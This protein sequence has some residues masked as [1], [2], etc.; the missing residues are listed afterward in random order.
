MSPLQRIRIVSLAQNV[1]GPVAA[2]RLLELG[3][4][5]VKVEP[6][7]GDPLSRH[8][9][10]WYASLSAGQQVRRIDLKDADGR[11][12]LES[13]LAGCDLLLTSS[14]PSALARL[15]LDWPRLH[16][17]HPHLSH[18]AI[19]G[20]A[21]PNGDAPGHDLTYLAACGLIEP[22][23]MPPTLMADLAG[24]ERAVSAALALLFARERGDGPGYAEV[25]LAAVAESL[26][27]PLRH[28]LTA[29]G[30]RLGG[31]WPGYNL[32]A[33]QGGWLAAAALEPH[34]WARLQGE[35][36]LQDAS[37][38]ELAAVFGARTAEEWARWAAERDLPL[39]VVETAARL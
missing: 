19:V 1:P 22:P 13:L 25:A 23:R 15:E 31:G 26:A 28:G 20:H 34:F 7:T 9:P 38:D 17:R 16:G 29:P 39:A 36:G 32:Y 35:L 30:G 6:P 33:A 8:A 10:E 3:A 12:E 24:A 5:L 37:Y 11:A 21:A 18:V 2:A 14:R 27:A 4:S